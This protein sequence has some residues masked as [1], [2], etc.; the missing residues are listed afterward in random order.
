MSGF[1][2]QDPMTGSWKPT[3]L[4]I[5]A[6]IFCLLFFVAGVGLITNLFCHLIEAITGETADFVLP[7]FCFGMMAFSLFMHIHDNW[8]AKKSTNLHA[9]MFVASLIILMGFV[10]YSTMFN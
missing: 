2:K 4:G 8:Y 7:A 10:L 6:I 3:F 1:M 9:T 5:A